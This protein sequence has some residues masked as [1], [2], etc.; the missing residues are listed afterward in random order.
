MITNAKYVVDTKCD[1]GNQFLHGPFRTRRA[2]ERFM[3]SEIGN[4][5]IRVVMA[6]DGWTRTE[7]KKR[8]T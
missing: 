4:S 7:G 6:P 5:K 3:I 2:A 8:G 1:N